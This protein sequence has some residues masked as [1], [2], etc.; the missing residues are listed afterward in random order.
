[1]V[2]DA[3]FASHTP[4]VSAVG[5]EID[6]V[7]SDFVAD[8]RAPTPSAAIEMILPDSVE[9]LQR[10]DSM[11][12][13]YTLIFG[14]ILRSKEESLEHLKRLFAKRSIDEKLSLWKNEISILQS[15]YNDKIALLHR[16]KSRQVSLLQEQIHFQTRQNLAKKEQ[17]L[18]SYTLA[19]NSKEPTREQ[20]ECYAQIVKEG[21]KIALEKIDEGETF[22]LQTPHTILKAKAVEKRTLK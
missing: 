11:M 12:E 15:Q 7:I 13:R 14:R 4:I 19:L 16:E 1:M 3:I 20:K 21:K 8:L 18:S 10:I 2:A 5:H 17:L 9:M 22:E 6:Y